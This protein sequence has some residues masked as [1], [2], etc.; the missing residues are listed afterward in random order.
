MRRVKR[1][2]SA[3]SREAVAW[4]WAGEG[5]E[6][7]GG[8]GVGGDVVA[9]GEGIEEELAAAGEPGD[10]VSDLQSQAGLLSIWRGF[11]GVGA[12]VTQVGG[13][14]LRVG[15]ASI[16][17][18]VVLISRA[19]NVLDWQSIRPWTAWTNGQPRIVLTE[20]S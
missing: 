9:G 15:A 11:R 17:G 2:G 3:V 7:T 10:G 16:I 19:R 5:A 12:T 13:I 6:G 8:D 18:K 4:S 1:E 20:T 14:R